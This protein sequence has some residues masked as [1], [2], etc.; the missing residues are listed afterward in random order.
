MEYFAMSYYQLLVFIH[1]L[2]FVLWL[3]ADVG[4]FMLGQHF[5][6]RD[7]YDLPQR[8][9]LLQLLV[10]L[11]MVPRT[12]WA[13]MVPITLTMADAGGWWD[14]PGWA[15]IL[16]WLV[17]GFWLWLVWDAHIHDQ[18]E[19]AARDR[20]IEFF[21]KIGLT[22]FYLGLGIASLANEAPLIPVWLATKALMFGLIFA[23]AIMI[24]VAFKPVGP[25]LGK[26]IAEGSSDETEIPLLRT[27]DRTRIWVW[28]VYLLLLATAFLGNVKPF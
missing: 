12:A 21:L 7:K 18:T 3:G 13:L 26:L 19:R 5:R 9:I 22:L 2:L 23:A 8:L 1:V 25:Q 4:V 14:L 17:G 28:I 11:D 10:S 24:D 15:V 6:K 27:M 16:A 20:M